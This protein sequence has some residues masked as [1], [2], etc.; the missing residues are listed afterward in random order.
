MKS[1]NNENNSITFLL[2][3][4]SK[5]IQV[6]IPENP[7]NRKKCDEFDRWLLELLEGDAD[8]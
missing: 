6:E 1:Y 3:E 4:C 8:E 7:K 2:T 5:F